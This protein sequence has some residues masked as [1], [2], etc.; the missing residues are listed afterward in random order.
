MTNTILLVF[1]YLF[2]FLA[3]MT[4]VI[5][6][7]MIFSDIILKRKKITEKN[8]KIYGAFFEMTNSQLFS[9]SLSFVKI[10]FLIFSIFMF[11]V[12][13]IALT[14]LLSLI[15]MFNLINFRMFNLVIDFV[16]HTLIYLM[17][18]SKDIFYNYLV[19]VG[20]EW[21]VVVLFIISI[22]FTLLLSFIL[23]FKELQFVIKKNKFVKKKI[24]KETIQ[25][26][27]FRKKEL[28]K[29]IEKVSDKELL[30]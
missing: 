22:L 23:F 28:K 16:I 11:R 27:L 4:V 14:V 7:L 3:I 18:L 19:N 26:G 2:A 9:V 21:Y 1:K 29:V 25:F 6:F 10:L 5:I 17:L 13:P 15:I 12:N 8:V 20:K 30:K 24:E